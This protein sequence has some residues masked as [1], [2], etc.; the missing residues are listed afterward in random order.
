MDGGELQ[1]ATKLSDTG[2]RLTVERDAFIAAG[3]LTAS[4]S[5]YSELLVL[6]ASDKNISRYSNVL[7]CFSIPQYFIMAQ[8][9]LAR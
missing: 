2:R 3:R 8:H 4:R 5:N 9:P 6:Q 7:R 1:D